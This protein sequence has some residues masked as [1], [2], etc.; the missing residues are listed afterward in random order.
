M[1]E[2]YIAE[3]QENYQININ[4]KH[5]NINQ[6]MQTI[7]DKKDQSVELQKVKE[8]HL[9][10]MNR[11]FQMKIRGYYFKICMHE[12]KNYIKREREWKRL[13]AY[14][15]NKF[16]RYR[17]RDVFKNWN[18]VT[19]QWGK[20]RIQKESAEYR[21]DQETEKLTMW[22]LKVDQMMLYLRQLEGKI[23]TEVQAREQLT[24]AYESSLNKGVQKVNRE[25]QLLADN[26]LVNEISLVVAKQLLTAS[27]QD[28]EALN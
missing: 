21:L 20:E 2:T 14:A 22:T 16:Y 18:K 19:H 8:Q 3:Y 24:I 25:T 13:C 7:Q 26:P 12:W 5:E 23:K 27:K 15:N 4:V 9:S 1:K 28:P 11:F 6:F 17:L 10:M